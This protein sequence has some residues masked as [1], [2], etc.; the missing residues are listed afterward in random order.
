MLMLE[1][2]QFQTR[3]RNDYDNPE[4]KKQWEAAQ[5]EGIESLA[6][7]LINVDTQKGPYQARI[8]S[9]NVKWLLARRSAAR[10]GDRLDITSG[11]TTVDISKALSDAKARAMVATSDAQDSLSGAIDA[12]LIGEDIATRSEA[13]GELGNGESADSGACIAEGEDSLA[14]LLG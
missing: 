6:D 12:V 5:V 9:E 7:S 2:N 8:Y 10:Y 13:G 1:T 14:K 11:V 3:R 4:L